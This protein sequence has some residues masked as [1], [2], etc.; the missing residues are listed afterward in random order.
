MRKIPLIVQMV[1]WDESLVR[2]IEHYD[3][4]HGYMVTRL[5]YLSPTGV[6]HAI[7]RSNREN[8]KLTIDELTMKLK[9]HFY[10]H[11]AEYNSLSDGQ[12]ANVRRMANGKEFNL[13]FSDRRT[14]NA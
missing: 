8:T 3:I 9:D 12:I 13:L 6:Q 7:N 4:D 11:Y 14:A 5:D 2:C 10:E 1:K